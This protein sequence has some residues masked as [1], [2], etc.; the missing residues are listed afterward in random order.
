MGF[1]KKGN[2]IKYEMFSGKLTHNYNLNIGKKKYPVTNKLLIKMLDKRFDEL[3]AKF[4]QYEQYKSWNKIV[5][6]IITTFSE[7]FKILC[8]ILLIKPEQW[9]VVKKGG[10]I[11]FRT[12]SD[13]GKTYF[14][15]I[16][17]KSVLASD[18]PSNIAEQ[19]QRSKVGNKIP[20]IDSDRDTLVSTD[21]FQLHINDNIYPCLNNPMLSD[22]FQQKFVELEKYH[23]IT[24]KRPLQLRDN[25][26]YYSDDDNGDN[27]DE[28][29]VKKKLTD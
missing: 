26:V 7:D 1:I 17:E 21:Y 16:I 22:L 25:I 12:K 8:I 29:S 28:L 15:T 9:T 19:I 4:R 14:L 2:K 24:F 18:L 11:G 23:A 3:L 10:Q 6:M 13:D 5:N 20:V 27:D